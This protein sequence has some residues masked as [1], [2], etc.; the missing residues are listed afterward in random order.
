[1]RRIPRI[2]H[3]VVEQ[4]FGL[5]FAMSYHKRNL[6]HYYPPEAVLFLTW[7][8]FGSLAGLRPPGLSVPDPGKSFAQTDRIL[9]ASTDGPF[10]LKDRHVAALVAGA[11]DQGG[12]EFRLYERFG[13]VIMPS[14]VHVFMR[15]FRPLPQLNRVIRYVEENPVRAGLAGAIEDWQCPAQRKPEAYSTA[16]WK[17]WRCRSVSTCVSAYST[18]RMGA[19]DRMIGFME[20]FHRAHHRCSA[21]DVR[22]RAARRADT[23]RMRRADQAET[24]SR[25]RIVGG[26]SGRVP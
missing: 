2:P 9:D 5:H 3:A 24:G 17:R 20:V 25:D 12:N 1:M 22:G 8:L 16:G 13:W 26:P 21:R 14:H 6:P 18:A 11:L 23:S 7:R 4:T 19:V 15:P 10:W